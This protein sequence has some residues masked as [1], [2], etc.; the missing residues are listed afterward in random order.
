MICPVVAALTVRTFFIGIISQ[1]VTEGDADFPYAT[2]RDN[3]HLVVTT[4]LYVHSG[5]VTR[6][7]LYQ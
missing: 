1:K 7:A 4:G 6:G 3:Y 2:R 5:V